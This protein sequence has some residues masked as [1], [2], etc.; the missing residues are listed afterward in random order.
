M[1]VNLSIFQVI[2]EY[3]NKTN[4]TIYSALGAGGHQFESGHPDLVIKGL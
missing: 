1:E 4:I 3:Y 2:T